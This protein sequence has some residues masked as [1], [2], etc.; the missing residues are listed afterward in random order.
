MKK[1]FIICFKSPHGKFQK[2]HLSALTGKKA[3]SF[4]ATFLRRNDW[5]GMIGE[6]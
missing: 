6:E 2:T 1:E 3:V 5:R 4:Y